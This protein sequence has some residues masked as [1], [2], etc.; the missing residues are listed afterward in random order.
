MSRLQTNVRLNTALDDRE[1]NMIAITSI[2]LVNLGELLDDLLTALKTRQRKR[3]HRTKPV[4]Q[5]WVIR[6][7]SKPRKRKMTESWM[8]LKYQICQIR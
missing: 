5:T 6:I 8:E 7:I 3:L 4:C 2:N 1:R